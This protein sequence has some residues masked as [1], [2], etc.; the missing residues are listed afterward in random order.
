MNLDEQQTRTVTAWI[1]E[2]LSLSE[3]QTRL[4]SELGL[5]LTYMEVRFLLDDLKL[6]PKDKEPPPAAKP[7][8]PPQDDRVQD[9][10]AAPKAGSRKDSLPTQNEP[11]PP[12]KGRLTV[13]VDQLTKPGAMVSGN[14]S[15]SDG[16]SAEWYLDQFGRLGV[17]P[18]QAGYKPSQSDLAA[19]QKEL[20]SELA[21]LGF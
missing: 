15:F 9:S 8:L 13:T 7:S 16:N 6:R 14:V 17:V 2:G 5:R 18:K 4:A 11:S 21:R 1:Q 3:I 20:Q 19:F 10:S 12:G